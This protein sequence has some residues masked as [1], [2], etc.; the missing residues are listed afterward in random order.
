MKNQSLY[1]YFDRS[2]WKAMFAVDHRV[3]MQMNIR[4][5]IYGYT[6]GDTNL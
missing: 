5:N 3:D 4:I 1:M 2:T 6:T